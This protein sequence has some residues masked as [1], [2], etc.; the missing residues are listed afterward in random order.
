MYFFR[1]AI[2]MCSISIYTR[3]ISNPQH[4]L[5]AIR[6]ASEFLSYL[7][8]PQNMCSIFHLSHLIW[9]P[10]RRSNCVISNAIVSHLNR[11]RSR[12]CWYIS[13]GWS[14][15]VSTRYLRGKDNSIW[16]QFRAKPFVGRQCGRTLRYY[17][18]NIFI[19]SL[20]HTAGPRSI[21]K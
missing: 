5:R 12:V 8:D 7:Q 18:A 21:I 3:F 9:S 13:F 10:R 15:V 2:Q 1:S 11:V 6:W 17:R 20:S 16:R 4:V 14:G 19:I